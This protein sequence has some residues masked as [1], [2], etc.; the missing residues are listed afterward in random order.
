MDSTL[1]AVGLWG[2]CLEHVL[3]RGTNF[4]ITE[5]IRLGMFE[6]GPPTD[7][8]TFGHVEPADAFHL[9]HVSRLAGGT[10]Q[11]EDIVNDAVDRRTTPRGIVGGATA[12][13]S[14]PRDQDRAALR[15]ERL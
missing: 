4:S 1:R 15:R 9:P 8:E 13:A 12:L 2:R 11:V 10:V 7:Q 14:V 6:V 5:P 3:G